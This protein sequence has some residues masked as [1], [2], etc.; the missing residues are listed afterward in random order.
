MAPQKVKSGLKAY[1]HSKHSVK[2]EAITFTR[3]V[4]GKE[5]SLTGFGDTVVD[6]SKMT[7]MP[8]KDAVGLLNALFRIVT[9]DTLPEWEMDPGRSRY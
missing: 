2:T 9:L 4:F 5:A 8:S 1:W 7:N 6:F 3:S